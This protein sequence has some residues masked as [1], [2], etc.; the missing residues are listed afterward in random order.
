MRELGVMQLDEQGCWI[1]SEVVHELDKLDPPPGVPP[2]W[3]DDVLPPPEVLPPP[4]PPEVADEPAPPPPPL[5][6]N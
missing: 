3:A 5:P 1:E 2:D 4:K 6:P